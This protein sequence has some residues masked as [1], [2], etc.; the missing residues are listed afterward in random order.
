MGL[1]LTGGYNSHF[2]L[3]DQAGSVFSPTNPP[4]EMCDEIVVAQESQVR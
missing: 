1:G 3:T 4:N 2:V